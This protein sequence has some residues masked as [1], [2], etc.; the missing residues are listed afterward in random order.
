MSTSDFD[1]G[2]VIGFIEGEGSFTF[3]KQ[4]GHPK[5]NGKI[6]YVPRFCVNQIN[7]EP[8]EFL[9]QFFGGG[10]IYPRAYTEKD[11]WANNSPRWDYVV[12]D[13]ETLKKVR[14]FCEGK[15]KHPF[16]IR[17]FEEWK[18]LFKN[19]YG[20]EGQRELARAQSIE[21]WKNP[22]IRANIISSQKA[23][24]VKRKNDR[25]P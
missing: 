15:L 6:T 23:G 22:I 2:W 9:K 14:D 25:T 20:K 24:W 21:R 3:D 19:F 12:N 13:I 1:K 4:G 5:K 10:H 16:K 8:L 11:Y 7:K 17:D 18:L